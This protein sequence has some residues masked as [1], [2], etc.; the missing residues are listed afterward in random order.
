MLRP[1]LM[2]LLVQPK[3]YSKL[4]REAW[5]ERH[6]LSRAGAGYAGEVRFG[7]LHRIVPI[8]NRRGGT[9]GILDFI[10]F[11]VERHGYAVPVLTDP[12]E[13]HDLKLEHRADLTAALA[14]EFCALAQL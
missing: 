14:R 4:Y 10:G 6:G 9:S 11:N 12:N 13:G 2:G 5:E 7:G 8:V 1:V 3:P